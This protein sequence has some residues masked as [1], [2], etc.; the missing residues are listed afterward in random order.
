VNFNVVSVDSAG[1]VIFN[2]QFTVHTRS[3]ADVPTTNLS[4]L[5]EAPPEVLTSAYV[6]AIAVPGILTVAYTV[7][8]IE[9]IKLEPSVVISGKM[10]NCI[11]M[12][13]FSNRHVVDIE[14]DVVSVTRLSTPKWSPADPNHAQPPAAPTKN[15]L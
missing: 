12:E 11:W 13:V 5:L 1:S 10:S 2:C 8:P 6:V 7:S 3:L 4:M 9:S 15:E 14:P